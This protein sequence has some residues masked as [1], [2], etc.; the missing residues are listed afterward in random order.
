MSR[1]T[2]TTPLLLG[3]IL[4]QAILLLASTGPTAL[5]ENPEAPQAEENPEATPPRNELVCRYFEMEENDLRTEAHG[6]I[7][8]GSP[9]GKIES[10]LGDH[11]TLMP[12]SM[13]FEM[14]QSLSGKPTYWVQICLSKTGS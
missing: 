2:Y 6:E 1:K 12:H 11:A 9:R 5:A 7:N 13:D 8:T 3:L 10:F 14:G 4:L